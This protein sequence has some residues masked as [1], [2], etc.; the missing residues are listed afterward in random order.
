MIQYRQKYENGDN[1][2]T[3]NQIIMYIMACGVLLGGVDRMLGNKWGYG[4]KFERGFN[5]LGPV[6]LSMAGIICLAPLLSSS[7]G[8]VIRPL[9]SVLHMDPG[10]FG[11]ILAIDM[12]GYQLSLDLAINPQIG[13]FAAVIVSSVFGV[14]L[15]FNIPVGL[16][17]ISEEDRPYFT[18]GILLGLTAIPFAIT[19]GG[20]IMGLGIGTILWNS[21]PVLLISLLLAI[22]VIKKPDAM[23]KGFQSFAKL[24]R[25]VA[26]LGL[27]LAAVIHLTG[28]NFLPAMPP[29]QDA[30]KTVSSICIVMLG[31]MPLA[32]LIQR[33][34]RKPFLWIGE[35]TGLNGASTTALLLGLVSATPA[36]AMI[37]DMNKRGKVVISAC[38][39]S[40][41]CTFGAHFAFTNNVQPDM[42]PS[43]LTTKLLGGLL[44]GLIAL[45]STRNMKE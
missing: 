44:G 32:E 36:L 35:K 8:V 2:M 7:L 38:L 11:S 15:V 3:I 1:T 26:T 40:C 39:V 23:M 14:T 45:A 42:V 28:L 25:I 19:A 17:F 27:T 16:G 24:I 37:P 12:G 6:G 29:L 13:R 5:M 33:L 22:G 10:I 18:R 4:E 43:L 34:M 20:L 31:S 30:M 9:C 41:V 21:V